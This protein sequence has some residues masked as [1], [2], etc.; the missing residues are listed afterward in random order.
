MRPLFQNRE[1]GFLISAVPLAVLCTATPYNCFG[2]I[3]QII[4]Q[5]LRVLYKKSRMQK[6]ALL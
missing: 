3:V 1:A 4:K 6:N 2:I 5:N